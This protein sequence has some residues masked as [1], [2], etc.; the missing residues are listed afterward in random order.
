[1]IFDLK[2]GNKNANVSVKLVSEVG[3]GTVAAGVSKGHADLVLISGHDGGTG[4]SPISSIRHA[5]TPWELGLSETQQVLVMN[6]L[7]SRITVQ[8]DGKLMT[9]RDVAI[10][11][12]LGAEEFG[13]ST[14]PL[15][16]LGC[17]MMRKCHLNTCPV[18][19]AT[20]D[21]ELRKKFEGQPESVINFFFFIAE[22]L[23]QIMAELGFH[24]LVD[25]VGRVD[26]LDTKKAIDHWKAKG[27]DFSKVFF[28][29]PVDKSIGR[30]RTQSQDHGLDVQLDNHL[31]KDAAPALEKGERV[32]IETDILNVNR[33]VGAMLSAEV[34]RR[35]G[36]KGLPDDTI[37]IK[38]KGS[39]GQSFGCWGAKG[40]SMTLEGD[41]NDY[42]G[43]GL[44]GARLVIYPTKGS[45]FVFEENIIIG[46]VSL[47]GAT[48]G[49]AFV[50]GMAGERFCIRN[51]GVTVVVEGVGD[52][53]CEYMTNGRV[54]IL[55]SAGRNFGAGMS[56][57]FAFILDEVGDFGEKSA[58]HTMIDLE[59]FDDPEDI[60]F[61]KQQI[62]RHVKYTNS[63]KGRWVL[64]N[65]E[66]ML[67][68]FIKI[69]PRELKKALSDRMSAEKALVSA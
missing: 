32:E 31:I 18:G 54:I 12:L 28:D 65:W 19:I 30:H 47:Y 52:H 26:M 37:N 17:I 64:D 20:Q 62:E 14:V 40:L 51:S 2:N 35:Y 46:N 39:A 29:P 58:N 10:G 63:P 23:R 68:K 38:L 57:G 49:E 41:A 45:S 13:F 50:N 67:P 59:P 44:S 9:G 6:D 3:V 69:F 60:A 8:V 56:G 22:E 66:K 27:L 42:F 48:S 43:K 1:M 5:G 53:G 11:A 61:V 15:I 16:S 4:A 24:K 25:M 21:P 36:S 55:G 7:R 34:S 33:T